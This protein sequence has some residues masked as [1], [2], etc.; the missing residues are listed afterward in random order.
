MMK[1]RN[2]YNELLKTGVQLV[3]VRELNKLCSKMIA[4]GAEFKLEKTTSV[5]IWTVIM[6]KKPDVGHYKMEFIMNYNPV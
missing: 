6:T 2:I 5:G 1:S 4:E 3:D